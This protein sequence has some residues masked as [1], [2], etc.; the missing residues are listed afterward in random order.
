L[1]K[2]GGWTCLRKALLGTGHYTWAVVE[3]GM[4]VLGCGD[5]EEAGDRGRRAQ[6]ELRVADEIIILMIVFRI[7]KRKTIDLAGGLKSAGIL[8]QPLT[9]RCKCIPDEHFV[10]VIDVNR[11]VSSAAS[12]FNIIHY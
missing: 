8:E 1:K 11:V 6:Q 4:K 10:N 2:L 5:A 12:F 9:H 3:A 7:D